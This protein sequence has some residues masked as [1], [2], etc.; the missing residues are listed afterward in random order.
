MKKLFLGLILSSFIAFGVNCGICVASADNFNIKTFDADYELGRDNEGRSLLKA[1]WRIT[2]DFPPNQNHGIAP[3]FVKSYDGHSTNFTLESVTDENGNALQYKWKDNELRIGDK[4][5]YVEGKK[6]Y[7]IKYSQRDVTKYYSD[8]KRDE[9]YW[10]VIGNEWRVPISNSRINIR[11]SDKIAAARQSAP[12]CYK[13]SH[14]STTRCDFIDDK[15]DIKFLGGALS[16]GEGVTIALGFKSGTFTP[17]Q[18]TLAEQLFENWL[19]LQ[20]LVSIPGIITIIWLA[21]SYYASIGRKSELNPITPEYIPPKNTSIKVSANILRRHDTLKGS[22]MAAQILDFAVRHYIKIYETGKSKILRTMHYEIEVTRDP[23]DLLDEEREVLSDM[24]N[25]LLPKVG[26]KLKLEKLQNNLSYTRRTFDDESNLSNLME[27][28]YDIRE[29]NQTH[30]DTFKKRSKI[31]L[32]IGIILL[33]PIILFAS[34]VSFGMSKKKVL[35]DKGLA[36]RRYLAGLKMYIE[37][38]ET[39]RLKMLQSPEGADKVKVDTNDEKQL[40]KLYERVLPYAVLFGSEKEWTKQ[41]GKYYE[42]VG[43]NPDWYYGQGTFNAAAFASGMSGLSSVASS[44]SSFSSSDGGSGGGGFTG[45]GG[46]GGGGGG[47]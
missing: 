10:D 23:Q 29:Y 20:I 11:L 1:T 4:D 14:G 5:T 8:T 30:G 42:Q 37:V 36:L 33:S 32:I 28:R 44:V 38:A 22:T 24:F 41:L 7:I 15:N 26:D 27:G 9:F 2:A 45:G 47:W 17:Y 25:G 39:E 6:T 40:V 12:N 13:G 19:F 35:T 16:R 43:S 46:G 31:L 34:A 3:T 21:I 18:K